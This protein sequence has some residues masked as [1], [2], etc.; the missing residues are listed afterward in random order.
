MCKKPTPRLVFAYLKPSEAPFFLQTLSLLFL[1]V[2]FAK[3]F[4]IFFTFYY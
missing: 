4:L 1:L 2:Y 3:S